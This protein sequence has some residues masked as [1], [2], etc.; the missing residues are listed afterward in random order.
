MSG[1][2]RPRATEAVREEPVEERAEPGQW[3]WV[4]QEDGRALACVVH[5]GSNYVEVE[6]VSGSSQRFHFDVFDDR[7]TPEPDPAAAIAERVSHYQGVVAQLMQDVRDV[8][9]RLGVERPEK[10]SPEGQQTYALASVSAVVD[11][12]RHREELVEAYEKTLP[13]LFSEIKQ[14]NKRLAS[15]LLADSITLKAT[16]RSLEGCLKRIKGRIFTVSLYAGLTEEVVQIQE[17]APAA[18]DERLRIMQRRLYMDE[19]CLLGYR[20]GGIEFRQIGQFDEWLLEPDNLARLMPYPRCLVAMQVRR[21]HK[22]REWSG[23]L[24]SAFINIHLQELDQRTFLF[25]RNGDQV[26]RLSC[27]LSFGSMIFPSRGELD[28]SEPMMARTFGRSLDDLITV[29]EYE[30][31]REKERRRKEERRALHEIWV[32]EHPKQNPR[33]GPYSPGWDD[34]DDR[35]A[36][37]DKSNLYYDDI[38]ESLKDRAE[39]Y[40]R[41]CMIVQGL[42]DRSPVFHPHPPVHLWTADGFA[43]AVELV[44][45]DRRL[46][47]GESP[48]FK[49]YV[50]R[51]NASLSTGSVT[52]GQEEVWERREAERE[53]D[54]LRGRGLSRE[55]SY[56]RF[57]P[58]GN[59]GPGYVARVEKWQKRARRAVYAWT[60]ERLGYDAWRRL[61]PRLQCVLQVDE[62]HLFNVSAYRPGDYLQF[63]RDPRT[64]VDY[65]RW[66]PLLMTAEEYHAGNVAAQEPER[67]P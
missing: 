36:P 42:F 33:Y 2:L 62:E 52:I 11:V 29:R 27:D 14:A 34:D 60:R 21:H 43:R 1:E 8:T 64:R 38:V 35:W 37:F 40:N 32:K 47:D 55:R 17:G 57:R 59:D 25:L 58:Y 53:N 50:R 5:V 12:G 18:F 65:L 45:E 3:Y 61:S 26:Y 10:A 16:A 4:K 19:E 30:A 7:L 31:R 51:C 46:M 44:Y 23:T 15:W 56:Q 63:F 9:A 13:R 24:A 41:I 20:Y 6:Y 48:S 49:D 66:A 67:L 22:D 54:R 39:K 28:L